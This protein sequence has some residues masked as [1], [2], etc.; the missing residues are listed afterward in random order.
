M[1]SC[2]DLCTSVQN[3]LA[4]PCASS[5]TILLLGTIE[6]AKPLVNSVRTRSVNRQEDICLAEMGQKPGAAVV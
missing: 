1:N 2:E 4:T 6:V 3:V 5:G